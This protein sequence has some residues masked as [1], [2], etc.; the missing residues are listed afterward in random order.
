[1]EPPAL[2]KEA[3]KEQDQNGLTS[4]LKPFAFYALLALASA[5]LCYY[6]QGGA[7]FRR[8]LAEGAGITL[9]LLPQICGA[10]LV[11]GFV[12]V[13]VRRDLVARWLGEKSG[14]RG[15]VVATIAGVMTPGGPMSSF[16]LVVALHNAGAERGALV[17][18]ITAWTLLGIQ[19]VLVWEIPLLGS[20]FVLIRY[21]ACLALPLLAGLIARR[22]P[23]SF[24]RP[25]SERR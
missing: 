19:R 17:V 3:S 20:E 24:E 25:A 16:P 1:M 10:F 4:K 21:L 18:Y 7:A 15:L 8:V 13:L 2:V 22:V 14:L 6:Q 11:A 9:S 5:A 23:M 12:Q